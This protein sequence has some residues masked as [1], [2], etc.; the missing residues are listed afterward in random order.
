[1]SIG[2]RPSGMLPHAGEV[3]IC[4]LGDVDASDAGDMGM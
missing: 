4:Y 1:M 3:D 2:T